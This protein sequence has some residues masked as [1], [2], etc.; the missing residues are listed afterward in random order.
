LCP[1]TSCQISSAICGANGASKIKY[2]SAT[3]RGIFSSSSNLNLL[4]AQ[5]F[6][7]LIN[8]LRCDEAIIDCPSTN[9]KAYTETLKSLLKFDT[10]LMCY[11]KAER[12]FQVG[13][14]SILAK[15]TRDRE[16]EKLQ[17]TIPEPMGS[18]YPSDPV[19]KEFLKNNWDKYPDIFRKSWSSYT[20]YSDGKFSNKQK[21]LS[22]F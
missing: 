1:K 13:A 3:P 19:T 5:N 8:S 14:A 17:S 22:D 21:N 2:L 12:F 18:G 9:I 6:A 10:T 7:E 4:E 15:V 11:H 20:A 16:I